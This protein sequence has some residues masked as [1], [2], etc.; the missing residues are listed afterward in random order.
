MTD[1]VLHGGVLLTQDPA[2]P[3]A[4]AV[5]VRDG[6][7]LAVGSDEDILPLA[8]PASR[9]IHLAGRVMVPGFNDAHA[10]VWKIGHLLTT[11]VDL[12][13]AASIAAI[14]ARL[15]A[16]AA[17]RPEGAWL[18]GRGWNEARLA[19]G[20]APT[21][22]DLDAAFPDRPVV[23]TRTCGHIMACNSAALAAA[24][25]TAATA[26]PA[27]GVI[28]RDTSGVP[29]GLV[30]ENAMGLLNAASPAPT[31]DD[32][33]AMIDAALRHQL[34][35]GIT[36]TN[37][38][39]VDSALLDTYRWMDAEG[40]LPSR[41]N[42]MIRGIVEGTPHLSPLTSYLSQRLRIDTVKF[43]ADG[44]L[45]GATA[46]LSTPYRHTGS[47]GVLRF[48]DAELLALCRT[49]HDA[50]FRIAVHAIGDVAIDQVLRVYEAL[51]RG[52]L[53]HRIE[54]LGL[55]SEE[56]LRRA[57]RLGVIV[58]PQSVFLHELGRNFRASL[59]E[60]WIDRTYPIR[61][62][63]DAGLTVA[64]SSD[65]P[66]VESDDPLLGMSAA[67]TRRTAEGETLAPRQAITAAAALRA[68]TMGGATAS[69][70]DANRGSLTA[71]KWADL[72]ILSANP[73]TVPPEELP[74]VRVEQTWLGGNLVHERAA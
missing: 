8:G 5:A 52:P 37:D 35:L 13:Q 31:R 36:S 62:M 39:G 11:M 63:L 28:E 66:V 21:R 65:A 4:S 47:R 71:G 15:Q 6:R 74:G 51:G 10:H 7:I 57:A 34:A 24:G 23:L 26:A 70:D 25:I 55:P 59:P 49:A 73:L 54:H 46:A 68:Y 67:V 30:H 3:A 32:Y 9:R 72:A 50:G 45:S 69:G 56:H 14:V 64:L 33:A 58:A 16:E 48:D 61:A 41:V 22:R 53:R 17:R 19:E 27:G 44:G 43:L 38:A 40:R 20:R 1:L 60:E 29:T 2:F 12:R 42:V 18:L